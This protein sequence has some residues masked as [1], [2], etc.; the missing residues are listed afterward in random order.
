M[1]E[2]RTAKNYCPACGH[3]LAKTKRGISTIEF[4]RIIHGCSDIDSLC[5]NVYKLIKIFR[6]ITRDAKLTVAF[7]QDFE[8]Q[9]NDIPEDIETIKIWL[10]KQINKLDKDVG[11]KALYRLLFDIYAEEGI[12]EPFAVF[13]D[14]YAERTDNP[15]SKNCVSRAL[16]ALGL[17][18]K[19]IKMVVNG[20]EKSV[21]SIRATREE[22]ISIANKN[23]IDY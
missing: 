5:E 1:V 19:M 12:N 3:I 7:S 23:G 14:I 16:R 4:R 15:L 8:K 6:Y 21:I 20:K 9:L 17:I 18:T 11:E 10:L 22:L 13:Y 2:Q